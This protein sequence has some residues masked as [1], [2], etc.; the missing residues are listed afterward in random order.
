MSLAGCQISPIDGNFHLQQSLEIF[1]ENSADKIWFKKD[2]EIKVSP[3]MPIRV[4]GIQNFKYHE[5]TSDSPFLDTHL[6][7]K[8]FVVLPLIDI[9]E[10]PAER[11]KDVNWPTGIS[12]TVEILLAWLCDHTMKRKYHLHVIISRD[13]P[14]FEVHSFVFKGVTSDN[15][16]F[17]SS[18]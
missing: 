13:Y 6:K 14:I 10:E 9:I 12:L 11:D 16:V 17:K 7:F 8:L 3:F 1:D 15:S 18:L 4:K 2:K 5:L